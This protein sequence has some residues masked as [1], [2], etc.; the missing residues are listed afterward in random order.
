MSC[1][2]STHRYSSLAP[3]ISPPKAEDRFAGTAKAQILSPSRN[4]NGRVC[5]DRSYPGITAMYGNLNLI[6]KHY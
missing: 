2:S 6:L 4:H 5:T 3:T 1:V